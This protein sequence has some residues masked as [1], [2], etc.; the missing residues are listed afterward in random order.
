MSNPRANSE[1]AVFTHAK[2][3]LAR[4]IGVW[5]V[6]VPRDSRSPET[7][8][9]DGCSDRAGRRH[10]RVRGGV[11]A[12]SGDRA[13]RSLR[14][15]DRER[16]RLRE[17]EARRPGE[18]VGRQRRG[19]RQHPGL[20][21]RHQRRPGRD[22]P[23][24]GRHRRRPTTG[25][26][27]TGWATTAAT[28]RARWRPSQPSAALPQAQPDCLT[29]ARD[30]PDRLRQ[31][32]RLGL[33]GGA[34]R[35][36]LGDL[37][38]EARARGRDRGASHIVFIVRDDDGGSDLLFQTSDTTWQAYNQYGGNSLYT[39]SPGRTRLQGQLQPP[40]H[41][42]R[43]RRPR[44][45]SSTP[46]TRWS[47]G[48]SE[49][50]TT[51]ATSPASTR[52]RSGAEILEHEVFLSVGH[53][54]YWSGGQRANVEA[55][56]DAGVDL[57]F[58]SGNE[59]FWKTRWEDSIAGPTT[60]HRTLVSYKE[61]HA[62]AK[63]DP[64]RRLDR[65]LARPARS[66]PR[67]RTRRTR[68]PA[69]SSRSTRG[70]SAIEVPAADGKMRLWRNTAVAALA[71]GPDRDAAGGHA[72]L[73]VG[74]GRSTTASR[75][76]GARPP[77]RRRPQRR[78]GAPGLRLDLRLRHRDAPPDAVPR[79][80]AARSSSAPARSSGRGA[81]TATTI[82]AA[83]TPDPDMQQA[84]VNLLADMGVA[85]RH[86]A[87]GPRRRDRVDRRSALRPRRSRRPATAPRSRPTSRPYDHAAPPP[88][89]AAA[90][91]AAVEVSIDG[92]ARGG[93][94]RGAVA[95]PTPGRRARP[96]R[97]RSGPGPPTT[98][99][100]SR[101]PA[102]GIAV[103]GRPGELPVLDLGAT[104]RRPADRERPGA[105]SSSGSSSAPTSAG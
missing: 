47:A 38:R 50:A 29:D 56:R 39:G 20:R 32:G 24:Q 90:R 4:K 71:R 59:V 105:R 68:S 21:D 48:S 26:T 36:R 33:V 99:A 103:D 12:Q 55:A 8:R 101:R 87:A 42:P 2:W 78:R 45:G 98:A 102:P 18:R 58:F 80:R 82:A 69:P 6:G 93:R 35:R 92:G 28:A 22:G 77:V 25:S 11:G 94:P 31:L 57:A 14:P 86:A 17:L 60:D 72:R 53:D 104:S 73:R 9:G 19:R 40:V 43:P 100:T 67:G 66:T 13:R 83:P 37:L 89:R 7:E 95:G 51:S 10:A 3:P 97:R 76:A 85:A 52:D 96:A 63:I 61:T 91:S 88:T 70:T 30:R 75:P 16:D 74:R 54:E 5:H 81:S 64:S 62:N 49:T 46:S 27:S 34:G 44:T 1:L 15:A 23:L 79:T 65:D 41:D 84:T